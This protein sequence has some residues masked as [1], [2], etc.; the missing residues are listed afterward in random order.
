MTTTP[1]FKVDKTDL[2]TAVNQVAKNLPTKAAQPILRAMLI[3]ADDHGLEL[4]G[5][6]Y[7]VSTRARIS[8]EVTGTGTVAVAGKLLAGIVS[9]LPNKPVEVTTD[10]ST[11]TMVCGASRFEFPLIPLDEYPKLPTLPA[12]TGEVDPALF[13]EAIG[14]VT[15]AAGRDDTLPML[16]GVHVT[17][18]GTRV[19]LVSTDRFR[20]ARRVFEWQPVDSGVQADLL[21]PAKTLQDNARGLDTQVG[22]PVGIALGEGAQVGADGIFGI[23]TDGGQTTTRMLDA[24]Y[25]GIDQLLP[26]GHDHLATVDISELIGAVKRV[27]LVTD[28]NAQIRLHFHPGK[29]IVSAGS[30]SSSGH[31][32]EVLS[33][34]FTGDDLLVAFNPTYLKDGLSVMPT[35]KAVFC[36]TTPNQPAVI[37]P[38]PEGG[39]PQPGGDGGYP[40]VGG[41]LLYLLMPVR[42]P[43]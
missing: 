31:A 40:P 33:C 3:T 25:P 43:A 36:F 34:D 20:L 12:L 26:K 1:S 10:E 19:E 14:Q 27:S 38:E 37:V 15:V 42:L 18:N 7:E 29:L 30:D 5:F 22:D 13:A 4:A 16:T 21:V 17:I 6:D 2:A 32:E 35:D 23:R 11:A 9:T 28:R 24:E 39:L 41:E 8:A